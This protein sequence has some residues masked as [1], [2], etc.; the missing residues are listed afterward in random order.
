MSY[1]YIVGQNQSNDVMFDRS[2]QVGVPVGGRV[3]RTG[4]NSDILDYLVCY[5]DLVTIVLKRHCYNIM[6]TPQVGGD[7]VSP[8]F[9]CLFVRT[10]N[11]IGGFS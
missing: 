4:T 11:A 3:A 7:N 8:V 6:L 10:Q 5:G 2:C 9:V 1:L